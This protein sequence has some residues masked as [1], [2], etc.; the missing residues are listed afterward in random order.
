MILSQEYFTQP[1]TLLAPDLLGKLLCRRGE[2]GNVIKARINETECYFGEKDTACHAHKGRT[3]R[4]D[5][6]YQKGGIAYVY[7][8]YGIHELFN[9]ITGPADHPEGVL[10][11]GV[12]GAEGPGR[13][14][15]YLG[16]T[17]KYNTLLLVPENGLWLEDDG[18]NPD[19]TTHPRVGIS[20]ASQEDQAKLWRF[21]VN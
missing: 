19:Y 10:I 6:L 2:N 13:A 1:A 21:K 20:Y 11:R 15:K 3:Q 5:T 7:L 8:C 9:V 18:D 12:E 4:T 16:I 14:T 17:R